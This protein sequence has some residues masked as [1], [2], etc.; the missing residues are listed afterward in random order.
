MSLGL[1]LIGAALSAR[2]GVI[3]RSYLREAEAHGLTFP[4]L[5]TIVSYKCLKCNCVV[6]PG[7]GAAAN[8]ESRATTS[9][10]RVQ[11]CGLPRNDEGRRPWP[12]IRPDLRFSPPLNGCMP[13]AA[14]A[15]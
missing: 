12:A 13:I 6:I 10:F 11:P 14:L 5:Q 9:R 15:T 8:P 1:E 7:R 3:A 4:A 2:L